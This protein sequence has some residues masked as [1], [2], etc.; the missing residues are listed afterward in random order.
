[1]TRKPFITH[2][3]N[4]YHSL[5]TLGIPAFFQNLITFA[6]GFV[7]NLMVGALGDSVISGVYMGN[8]IQTLLQLFTGGVEGSILILSAQYWGKQDSN[9]I[10]RIISV[11]I[12][13]SLAF[14]FLIMIFSFF[15]PATIIS[16][17]THDII[18]IAEGAKYLKVVCLSYCFFCITQTLLAAMRSVETF[19]IGMV[20][21]FFSLITNIFLNLSGRKWIKPCQRSRVTGSGRRLRTGLRKYWTG[22][23]HFRKGC[24][25]I[26]TDISFRLRRFI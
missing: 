18:V 24:V 6:V 20:I 4:F 25:F 7:D 13:F 12:H 26:H 19:Q 16:F 1:M 11:G 2:D 8:Q 3:K 9:S 5:L 15:F 21:S 14:G 17:F 23:V 10:K 22:T